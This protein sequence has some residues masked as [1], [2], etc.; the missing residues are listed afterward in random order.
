MDDGQAGRKEE[1]EKVGRADGQ[2]HRSSRVGGH[3]LGQG[4][5]RTA[6]EEEEEANGH[7]A[8]ILLMQQGREPFC[9]HVERGVSA[10]SFAKMMTFVHPLMGN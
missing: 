3:G 7:Y 10:C 1:R 8:E 5:V 9:R 4:P 6:H 2:E